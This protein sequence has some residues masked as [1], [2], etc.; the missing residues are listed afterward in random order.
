MENRAKQMMFDILANWTMQLMQYNDTAKGLLGWL[1]GMGPQMSTSTNV[2][3]ALGSVFGIHTGTA[4]TRGPMSETLGL[5]A[6]LNTSSL[7][8][9]L[10]TAGTSL[11]AAGNTLSSSGTMLTTSANQL[12]GA[13]TALQSAASAMQS[14][15]STGSG[16][17]GARRTNRDVAC[18]RRGGI[19]D[20]RRDGGDQALFRGDA[21]SAATACCGCMT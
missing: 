16:G 9:T 21:H 15:G 19:E 17:D 2:G 4:G 18:R 5:P 12:D 3:Q 13:A 1:F 7:G 14:S 8:T 6:G 10:T 11:N 20:Q